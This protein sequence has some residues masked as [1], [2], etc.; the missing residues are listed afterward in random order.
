ML[1]IIFAHYSNYTNIF[2]PKL[3]IKLLKYTGIN[4]Y[5]IKLDKNKQLTY[6]LIYNLGLIKLKILKTYTK[7]NLANDLIKPSKLPARVLI[8]L[9]YKFNKNP[10]FYID[11]C[12]LNNLTI[13]NHYLHFLIGK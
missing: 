9:N 5:T 4:N 7:I 13:K 6:S 10:C 12:S 11:Y 1:I 8:F 3:I 2:L